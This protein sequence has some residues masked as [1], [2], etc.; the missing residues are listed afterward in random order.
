MCVCVCALRQFSCVQIFATPWIITRQ[1]PPSMG[2]SRQGDWSRL[3]CPLPV[4]LPNPEIK[5]VSPASP[6]LQLDSL[7][8]EPPGSP[9]A[10]T[11]EP[12]YINLRVKWKYW[13]VRGLG[14]SEGKSRRVSR[15]RQG[16]NR[17]SFKETSLALLFNKMFTRL[18][19]VSHVRC[20]RSRNK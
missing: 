4:D 17:H 7:P 2:L 11:V 12:K 9:L 18:F 14:I 19:S 8:T 10:N 3:P 13:K 20:K 5:P 1:A 15:K 16:Y 6:A